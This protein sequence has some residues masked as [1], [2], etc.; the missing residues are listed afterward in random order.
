MPVSV[1][2]SPVSVS[3]SSSSF[4][5]LAS[6]STCGVSLPP[7]VS[8]L[9]WVSAMRPNAWVFA[10]ASRFSR[11]GVWC[12]RISI[13][14]VS[15]I[16]YSLQKIAFSFLFLDDFFLVLKKNPSFPFFTCKLSALAACPVEATLGPVECRSS[17]RFV[18]LIDF[19]PIVVPALDCEV[20]PCPGCCCCWDTPENQILCF[21]WTFF[22]QISWLFNFQPS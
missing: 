19:L 10:L 4:S 15:F 21:F 18:V 22:F 11:E 2:P 13:F 12:W 14:V 16:S 9:S 5:S 17:T 3:F 1:D 6:R 20:G 8:P 7:S